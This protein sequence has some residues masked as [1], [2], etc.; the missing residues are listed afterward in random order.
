MLQAYDLPAALQDPWKRYLLSRSPENYLALRQ[1]FATS[2]HYRPSPEGQ[3]ELE[4][5]DQLLEQGRIEEGNEKLRA[6]AP[7]WLLSPRLHKMLAYTFHEQGEY[8]SETFELCTCQVVLQ[9]IL[10]TGDGSEARPYLVS[11]GPDAE[12]VLAHLQK[13]SI[14]TETRGSN[15]SR[16]DVWACADGARLWFDMTSAVPFHAA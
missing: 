16:R 14:G 7:G 15:G 5:V 10:W 11:R 2:P 6:M 4:L 8:Q 1:A 13:Q 12:D 9:G 3:N